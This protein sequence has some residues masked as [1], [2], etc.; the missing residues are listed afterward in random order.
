MAARVLRSALVLLP[1]LFV[2]CLGCEEPFRP[3]Y[4]PRPNP[5]PLETAEEEA[6]RMAIPVEIEREDTNFL[7]TRKE[8]GRVMGDIPKN[9]WNRHE[10]DLD[11][12]LRPLIR[13]MGADMGA[14]KVLGRKP[15]PRPLPEGELPPSVKKT[16][17]AGEEKKAEEESSDE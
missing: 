9:P 6:K 2:G 13:N 11:D 3:G 5:T 16:D 8:V 15:V 10:W 7:V 12:T 1:L 17:K 4:Q 14:D